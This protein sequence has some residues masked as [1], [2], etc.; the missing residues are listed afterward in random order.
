MTG[1]C[2]YR[3]R[4]FTAVDERFV[5]RLFAVIRTILSR[6]E[7]NDVLIVWSRSL[8]ILCLFL[9]VFVTEV[10]WYNAC[11]NS[12]SEFS[13]RM[14]LLEALKVPR[15]GGEG[16][17]H[18]HSK[19][20]IC[21][22][23]LVSIFIQQYRKQLISFENGLRVWYTPGFSRRLSRTCSAVIRDVPVITILTVIPSTF[24]RE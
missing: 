8:S 6:F 5:I 1:A 13:I 3:K 18:P 21:L 7:D 10:A 22:T 23:W 15:R 24:I 11:F 2:G 16:T 20:V 14:H 17:L 19:G 4:G 9:Y 12:F